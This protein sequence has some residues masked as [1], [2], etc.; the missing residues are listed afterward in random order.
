MLLRSAA[1]EA[2][3]QAAQLH[4]AAGLF[5]DERPDGAC[6]AECP[7]LPHLLGLA[8]TATSQAAELIAS[9]E[10]DADAMRSRAID[11]SCDRTARAASAVRSS[12]ASCGVS[13]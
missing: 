5:V 9:L 3:G 2:P 1:L 8:V 11:A 7:A 10:V 13:S 4:L 6:H 12:Q